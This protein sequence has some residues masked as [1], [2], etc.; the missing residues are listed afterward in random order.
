MAINT[1]DICGCKLWVVATDLWPMGARRLFPCFDEPIIQ[2]N[3][4]ILIKHPK[5][6]KI[7]SNML[8]QKTSITEQSDMIWTHFENSSNPY[9]S[10]LSSFS[11]TINIT[12]V[13]IEHREQLNYYYINF[14][15]S[16]VDKITQ[17]FKSQ[18]MYLPNLN[19]LSHVAIPGFRH[20]AVSN[21][22]LISY[23]PSYGIED[24]KAFWISMQAAYDEQDVMYLNLKRDNGGLD[25]AR[26]L[27]CDECYAK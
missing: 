14:T 8:K 7:L 16:V 21:L 2:A 10:L 19:Q 23:S 1:Q 22:G 12:D 15:L 9:V 25:D 5:S 4:S 24:I 26:A 20:D 3:F 27:S 6:Y 11:S 13:H 17:Y 18:R